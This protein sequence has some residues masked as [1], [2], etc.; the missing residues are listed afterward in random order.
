MNTPALIENMAAN[1]SLNQEDTVKDVG[2]SAVR[3]ARPSV[4]NLGARFAFRREFYRAEYRRCDR[5]AM[6]MRATVFF[7]RER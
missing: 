6:G 7:R 4:R 5:A 3:K 2:S 1:L